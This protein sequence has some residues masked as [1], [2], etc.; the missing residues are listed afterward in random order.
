LATPNGQKPAILLEEL[1]LEYD[2]FTINILAG[3][4]FTSGFVAVNP[5]SKIPCAIDRDGPQGQ[6][7]LFVITYRI[8]T[9]F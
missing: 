4:Q 3:E 8:L 5:N 7:V 2:A 1:G 6:P 9:L